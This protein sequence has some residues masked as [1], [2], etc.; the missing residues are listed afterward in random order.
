MR[1]QIQYG[2]DTASPGACRSRPTASSIGTDLSVQGVRRPGLGLKRGLAD[3]LVVAPYATAL[4]RSR[5]PDRALANLDASPRLAA[6]GRFGYYDAID[7][8][9]RKTYEAERPRGPQ[10]APPGVVVRTYMAHHQGMTL[11]ALA[12]V[13]LDDV[14]VARFHARSAG[15]G[16]RAA[17]AGT[18]AAPGGGRTAAA[19]GREPARAGRADV[20]PRRFRSPHTLYPH[21][22]FLSNGSYVAVVT[23]AGGGASLWRG[24]A[25]TR[26]RERSRRA[27]RAASSSTCATCARARSGRRPTSRRAGARRIPGRRSRPSARCSG[28]RD[29][30]IETQLEVV[31]SAE[32]D[33]EV[34]RL[35]LTNTSD[36][37]REIE[38]TSYAEIVLGAARKTTSRIRPSASCSSRPSTCRTARRCSAAPAA[39]RGRGGRLGL[40]RAQ[41][42]RTARRRRPNGRPTAR[43]SSAAAAAPTDPIALDGRALSGTTGAV[44]D[45]VVSL[46]AARAAA[47]RRIRAPVVRHRRRPPIATPARALAQ[48]YHDAGAAARAFSMAYTHGRCCCAIWASPSERARQYDRL[49]SRVLYL[50]ESLRAEPARSLATNT[51]GQEAC[52]RTAS[53]ATCRSCWSGRRGR[54]PD[55]RAPGAAGAGVLAAARA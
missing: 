54:R 36:R 14:M 28:A 27:T 45:P 51:L 43:A 16:H 2:R 31:V 34:R 23:N 29:D 47:A 42:R 38:V 25:V 4:A 6:R 30:G 39:R 46:R 11:V 26:W 50:D 10:P 52:G 40:P 24:L 13:L 55:A 18:R 33:V 21:A 53:P 22:Q 9:P 37:T 19:G 20:A 17:A 44:L 48:K 3:D 8:T 32:D 41:R 7:Y 15:P 1:R 35:S 12:N 5:G 49:A